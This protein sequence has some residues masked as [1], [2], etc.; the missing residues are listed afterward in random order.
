[1]RL[2]TITGDLKSTLKGLGIPT[3]WTYSDK[4]VNGRVGVKVVDVLLS[5]ELKETVKVEMQQKGYTFHFIRENGVGTGFRGTR[6][7]FSKN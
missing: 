2:G 6:F 3:N 4:Y 1:M 5:D 7:C